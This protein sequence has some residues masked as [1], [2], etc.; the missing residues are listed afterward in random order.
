MMNAGLQSDLIFQFDY[1][2]VEMTIKMCIVL[3]KAAKLC[4]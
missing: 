4:F 3:F 1:P 2:M